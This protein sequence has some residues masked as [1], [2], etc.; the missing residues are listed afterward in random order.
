ML[1]AIIIVQGKCHVTSAESASVLFKDRGNLEL[2]GR[3]Y[4]VILE[5]NLNN[6]LDSIAPIGL[7]IEEITNGLDS[8]LNYLESQLPRRTNKRLIPESDQNVTR[9]DQ[10]YEVLSETMREHLRF[11]TKDLMQRHH[12]LLDFVR[13]LENSENDEVGGHRDARGLVDG[14]GSLLSWIFGLATENEISETNEILERASNLGEESRKMLNLH[15]KILNN[16]AVQFEM[17]KT[18]LNRVDDCL[19]QVRNNV[20]VLS[21]YILNN[22]N[23]QFRMEHSLIITNSLAYASSAITDLATQ[24]ITLKQ[25]LN[26]LRQGYI[27][28]ELMPPDEILNLISQISKKNLNPI[29]PPSEEYLP[30]LYKY[31]RVQS[32]PHSP[33]SFII[34]IPLEGDPRIHLKVYEI[35]SLPHP[36]NNQLTLTYTDLPRYIAISDDRRIF[37]EY[38]S[39]DSCRHHGQKYLCPI[40]VPVYREGAPSCALSLFKGLKDTTD[41]QK[42]FSPA[43]VRP[44]LT[45][46][47]AGWLYSISQEDKITI[48]CMGDVSSVIVK[49]GSG[50]INVKDNCK[51]TSRQFLL[52]GSADTGGEIRI[53]NVSTVEPFHLN[54]SNSEIESVNLLN[55]SAIFDDVMSLAHN[56]LSLKSLQ[57]EMKNLKYVKKMRQINSIT[58]NAGLSLAVIS[59]ISVIIIFVIIITFCKVAEKEEGEN[60][61]GEIR[62]KSNYKVTFNNIFEKKGPVSAQ[63]SPLVQHVQN[64]HEEIVLP[65]TPQS[66]SVFRPE[67]RLRTLVNDEFI[68]HA[69]NKDRVHDA[70]KHQSSISETYLTEEQ[71]MSIS[72]NLETRSP[73]SYRR[74]T[75]P[76]P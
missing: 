76:D 75:Y 30:A 9:F 57:G 32:L 68:T 50:K 27:N 55:S 16:S 70:N 47:S 8:E 20:L 74:Y 66:P 60:T 33:L 44:L 39:L 41:C 26:K 5:I 52:P 11:L 58:G 69:R 71:A 45:R 10:L 18:H 42:H 4:Y 62:P 29:L 13:S 51:I 2:S 6:L 35:F 37:I 61:E 28:S 34:S 63:T 14:G 36:I 72:S 46:T 15:T 24:F 40:E 59:F 12:G 73:G 64:D 31:I 54:L 53:Y 38:E 1:L 21:N 23:H 22:N 67:P 19:D 17:I 3:S 25:G 7:G 43:L 56:K 49:P 65:S 48:T